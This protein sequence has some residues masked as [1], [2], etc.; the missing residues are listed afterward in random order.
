MI[1]GGVVAIMIVLT[2]GAAD[3]GTALIARER[4][5]A[6]A[7][8]AA[9]AA[10][11]ELAMPSGSLPQI[12]AADY[13]SRNGASLLS[14]ACE[15]GAQEALVSVSVTIRASLPVPGHA[16]RG[17]AVEG[18][19]RPPMSPLPPGPAGARSPDRACW[20]LGRAPAS[21]ATV[22]DAAG[23]CA[24]SLT[25]RV[26]LG[27]HLPGAKQRAQVRSSRRAD[28][29]ADVADRLVRAERSGWS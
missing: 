23:C 5:H 4:A 19:R 7:D 9:L 21:P 11:Q 28:R 6:A 22:H 18:G 24:R 2:L 16:R 3:L 27:V 1:I 12:Q 17:V 13:A 10:A 8:A 25:E 26:V 20:A 14:C 15:V 29:D